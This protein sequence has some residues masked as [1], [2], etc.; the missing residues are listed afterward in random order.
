MS[1]KLRNAIEDVRQ[2]KDNADRANEAKSSFLANVS[3]ELRTPLNAIIGYSE[4]LFDEARTRAKRSTATS[5]R[6]TSRKSLCRASCCC[7]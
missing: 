6:S 4:M 3:H 7:R 1:D 2:A 5:S